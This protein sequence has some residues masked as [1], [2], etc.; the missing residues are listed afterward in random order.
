[1]SYF[2]HFSTG[3]DFW[4]WI[5]G[6][7]NKA[8]R[9]LFAHLPFTEVT[10][11]L[12]INRFSQHRKFI[13]ETL[14]NGYIVERLVMKI[15]DFFA[16]YALEMLVLTEAAVEPFGVAGTFDDEGCTHFGKGKKRP[17]DRIQRDVRKSF[18]DL[19]VE[20]ICRR[21][22]FCLDKRPVNRHSLGCYPQTRLAA[23]VPEKAHF[24]VKLAAGSAWRFCHL[25]S[26]A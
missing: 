7:E 4:A 8:A 26:P 21:V 3:I 9:I 1:V 15:N 25:A 11:A 19:L 6:P 24:L 2:L 22:L 10:E 23:P 13:A 12:K 14:W 5:V 20:N 18:S 17:V 16:S